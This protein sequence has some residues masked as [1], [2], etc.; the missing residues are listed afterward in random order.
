MGDRPVCE[1]I[2]GGHQAERTAPL[3]HVARPCA[4]ARRTRRNG[5][6]LGLRLGLGGGTAC[7]RGHGGTPE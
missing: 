3:A 6:R 2:P 4:R 7:G 5:Q 1:R